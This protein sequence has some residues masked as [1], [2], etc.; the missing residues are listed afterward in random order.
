MR[1]IAILAAVVMT[2]SA[3]NA[4]QARK[5]AGQPGYLGIRYNEVLQEDNA[6]KSEAH[7]TVGEVSKDSP[8][9]KAGIKAGD[10][11]IRINGL[12]AANG[13]FTA[14]ARTLTVGDTV[15]LRI[16]R[17]GKEREYTVV[18]APR[19]AMLAY[20]TREIRI[21]PDS[22]RRLML[23]YLD[24]A[25]VHLDS[26]KLPGMDIRIYRDDDSINIMPFRR[27]FRDSV[28]IKG[29]STGHVFRYLPQGSLPPDVVFEREI[30]GELGPGM[31]FRS[32]DLGARS[33]GGAELTELDPAM[34]DYFKV[35]HGLLVLRV[36]PQTP[37][38]RA[39][40][41]PGDVVIKAGDR[42]V[43]RVADLRAIVAGNP[44][45]VKLEILRKG[46]R[47]TLELK[48]RK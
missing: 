4:Q 18:A 11:I 41:E 3:A 14:I 29:D 30:G 44:E 19:P 13:K 32:I 8:A 24:S 37:A 47:K 28:W 31:V 21:A 20:G 46:E 9:E 16:E 43:T 34:V 6:G 40:L 10:E 23:K 12:T 45:A 38:D 33:I 15:R 39:G 26:L 35:D 22:V 27:M 36:V 5:A 1:T 42:S 25:R 7:V 17:A 2:A 48:T